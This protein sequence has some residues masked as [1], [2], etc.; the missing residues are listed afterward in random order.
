MA[1]QREKGLGYCG[2]A[3]C[4]CS[5]NATC[6]GCRNEGCSNKEWCKNFNCCKQKGLN[7]CWQCPEFPCRGGMLDKLRIR[8]FAGFIKEMG[9]SKLM[10]C[11]E[12]NEKNG[13]QYH[14]PIGLVG[15][16]DVGLTE[17]EIIAI[18][19]RWSDNK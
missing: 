13:I 7:G 16:Y 2:L 9:E 5:E 4:V 18:I 17:D 10:D 19:L 11:L 14:Y 12:A 6:P 8:T 15:D 3:C 1:V